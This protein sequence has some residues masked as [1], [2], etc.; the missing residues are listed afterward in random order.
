MHYSTYFDCSRARGPQFCP[1]L[2][3]FEKHHRD[4]RG[5]GSNHS[6]HFFQAHSSLW[7]RGKVLYQPGKNLNNLRNGCKESLPDRRR[8]GHYKGIDASFDQWNI[9]CKRNFEKDGK[10]TGL[11]KINLEGKIATSLKPELWTGSR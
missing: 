1:T 5:L 3:A 4:V 7:S 11:V 9:G 6:W 8:S 10:R 2:S